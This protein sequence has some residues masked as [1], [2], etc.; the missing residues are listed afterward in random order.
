VD[1]VGSARGSDGCSIGT[2]QFL[3][4]Y[5]D[6]TGFEG[7][8]SYEVKLDRAKIKEQWAGQTTVQ[9]RA[10]WYDSADQ[11]LAMVTLSTE[12]VQVDGSTVDDNNE[13]SL[14]IDPGVRVDGV[15]AS[16][17]AVATVVLGSDG[18]VTITIPK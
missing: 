9:F 16:L 13:I 18:T 3:S 12:R 1:F 4:F 17:V 2:N 5:G 6:D 11:G 8:E 15:C 7:S 14:I 10:G